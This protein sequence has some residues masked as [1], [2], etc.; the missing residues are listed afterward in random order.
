M[1]NIQKNILLWY[2]R[3]WL[4][5][6]GGGIDVKFWTA[7]G[8]ERATKIEQMWTRVEFW[9]FGDVKIECSPSPPPTKMCLPLKKSKDSSKVSI[10]FKANLI[11]LAS[12]PTAGHYTNPWPYLVWLKVTTMRPVAFWSWLPEPTLRKH[13]CNSIKI[14]RHMPANAL[15]LKN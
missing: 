12:M 3:S 10:M 13:W 6:V 8:Q 11:L 14:G 4:L 5:K 9:S 2:L 7:S 15:I 1:R